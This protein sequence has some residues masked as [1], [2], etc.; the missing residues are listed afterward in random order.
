MLVVFSQKHFCRAYTGNLE[1]FKLRKLKW[2]VGI[3]DTFFF[4]LILSVIVHF[5]TFFVC[6]VNLTIPFFWFIALGSNS[7][8]PIP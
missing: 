6:L 5:N 3:L 2:V 4:Y 8:V 7:F 1:I